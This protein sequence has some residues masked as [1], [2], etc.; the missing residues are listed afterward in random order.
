M[1]VNGDDKHTK[2]VDQQ[3]KKKS[4]QSNCVCVFVCGFDFAEYGY[5]NIGIHDDDQAIK[6]YFVSF[7]SKKLR[8]HFF[9]SPFFLL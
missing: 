6:S 8:H 3:W 1:M 5:D 2:F 9:S 4:S 7:N